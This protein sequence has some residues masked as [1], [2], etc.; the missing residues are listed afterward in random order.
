[1]CTTEALYMHVLLYGIL[2]LSK[3]AVGHISINK[4]PITTIQVS[5]TEIIYSLL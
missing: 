1:M 5:A 4:Q 2:V 3:N